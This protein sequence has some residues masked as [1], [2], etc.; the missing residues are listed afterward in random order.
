MRYLELTSG[1]DGRTVTSQENS[2]RF[3]LS[4]ENCQHWHQ[5]KETC[6]VAVVVPVSTYSMCGMKQKYLSF[7]HISCYPHS[8][9]NSVDHFDF[10]LSDVVLLCRS[11]TLSPALFPNGL[12]WDYH[13]PDLCLSHVASCADLAYHFKAFSF[14]RHGIHSFQQYNTQSNTVL[15]TSFILTLNNGVSNSYRTLLSRGTTQQQWK[16]LFT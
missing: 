10:Y 13:R 14:E 15:S 1:K 3:N 7:H 9:N 11:T 8:G 12:H 5:H 16:L 2:P 6:I 4:L